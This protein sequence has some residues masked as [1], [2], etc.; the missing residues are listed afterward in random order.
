MMYPPLCVLNTSARHK[1]HG[2]R[3]VP[4][5]A[6]IRSNVTAS[7]R[8]RRFHAGTVTVLA[9]LCSSLSG[10]ASSDGRHKATYSSYAI[11]YAVLCVQG[12]AGKASKAGLPL[13]NDG[14]RCPMIITSS[15]SKGCSS[16]Q[17]SLRVN[18]RQH[19][20]LS[21]ASTRLQQ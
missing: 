18:V 17:V 11:E 20:V 2:S 8:A 13:H 4:C 1:P 16:S 10:A 7:R 9:S 15:D 5:E 3:Q 14:K 21:P 6:L 12:I 19:F